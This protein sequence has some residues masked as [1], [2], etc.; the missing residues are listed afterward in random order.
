[1][2]GDSDLGLTRGYAAQ[3]SGRNETAPHTDQLLP[4]LLPGFEG[5]KWLIAEPYGEK[6]QHR[7]AQGETEQE[8]SGDFALLGRHE[9]S[10]GES[11]TDD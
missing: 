1:M 4:I 3:G 6:C 11:N 7:P 2:C 9:G 10:Y 8:R 5:R